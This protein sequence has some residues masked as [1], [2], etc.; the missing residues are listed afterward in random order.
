MVQKYG[1]MG[2]SP[3]HYGYTNNPVHRIAYLLWEPFMPLESVGGRCYNSI[4]HTGHS[5]RRF[6]VPDSSAV[7]RAAVNR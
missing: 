2:C 1:D 7:E 3:P 6:S 4:H 5:T